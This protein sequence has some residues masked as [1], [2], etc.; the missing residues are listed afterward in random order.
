MLFDL[1][2]KWETEAVRH[3][4]ARDAQESL[5]IFRQGKLKLQSAENAI[6]ELREYVDENPISA[7]QTYFLC[8]P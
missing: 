5:A 8:R 4:I 7:I 1:I 6:K 3:E 2:S